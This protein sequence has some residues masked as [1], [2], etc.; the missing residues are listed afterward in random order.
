MSTT[1]TLTGR[2]LVL[3]ALGLSDTRY[4][5]LHSGVPGNSGA[6]EVTDSAYARQ[7]AT[8]SLEQSTGL[9]T[10]SAALNWS[11]A[12]SGYTVSYVGVWDAQF[13]G[14][15]VAY[16]PMASSQSVSANGVFTIPAGELTVG[17]A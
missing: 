4:V 17:G 5:S 13:G 8:F 10:T 3:A 9:A 12:V 14:N 2:N 11:A 6:N 15:L 1:L 16:L 7:A